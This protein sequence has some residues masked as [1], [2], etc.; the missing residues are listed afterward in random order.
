MPAWS[1][2]LKRYAWAFLPLLGL[3]V[4]VGKQAVNVLEALG[5]EVLKRRADASVQLAA[6]LAEDAL[7]GRLLDEGVLED[8]LELRVAG[9]L[10]HEFARL[11]TGERLVKSAVCLGHGREHTIEERTADDRGQAQDLLEVLVEAVDARHDHADQGVGQ[12]DGCRPLGHAIAARGAVAHEAAEVDETAHDLLDEEGVA[13]RFGEDEVTES[14]REI[15]EV[16]QVAHEGR[17]LLRR[18]WL[19]RDIR[20]AGLVVAGRELLQASERR[21]RLG[22]RYAAHHQWKFFDE[23]QEVLQQGRR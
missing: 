1:A 5:K 18:E 23:R 20:R 8:V 14:G 3:G 22:P 6:A 19:Q 10:E 12:R 4:V 16:D 17:A 11:Q 21:V 15:V 9:T 7:V 2:A 13:L